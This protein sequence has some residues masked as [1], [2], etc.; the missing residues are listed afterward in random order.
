MVFP[1]STPPRRIDSRTEFLEPITP[2]R[3]SSRTDNEKE[4]AQALFPIHQRCM[5]VQR[6]EDA[7]SAIPSER[8]THSVS[9]KHPEHLIYRVPEEQMREEQHDADQRHDLVAEVAPSGEAFVRAVAP[10][11]A[12]GHVV[13]HA[14]H[15]DV[16]APASPPS[17]CPK[18]CASTGTRRSRTAG[19]S[20]ASASPPQWS[21]S[22]TM[23]L[24][25]QPSSN[26]PWSR[27]VT[28]RGGRCRAGI[29]RG[30]R[31]R[32]DKIRFPDML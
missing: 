28:R 22:E 23:R 16:R 29:W 25:A 13:N 31:R 4:P 32:I 24:A 15:G 1:I 30:R 14:V 3:S 6:P 19:A 11:L 20:R 5:G 26:C 2:K 17:P 9:L 7:V 21:S 8:L 10:H 18:P 12:V 27:G